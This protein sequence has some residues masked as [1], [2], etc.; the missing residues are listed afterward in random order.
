[1]KNRTFWSIA[2][3]MAALGL[4]LAVCTACASDLLQ[5]SCDEL[6]RTAQSYREDIKTVDI[7]LGAAID[8]GNLERIKSYKL[9]KN[10]LKSQLETVLK[11]V[12][13]KDCARDK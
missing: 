12:D 11:A 1:M 6:I 13:L 5:K 2:T 7:V 4:F 3:A 10:A 8:A 9:R